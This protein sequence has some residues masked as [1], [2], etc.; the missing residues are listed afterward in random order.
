MGRVGV[1]YNLYTTPDPAMTNIAQSARINLIH[2]HP[3]MGR[4]VAGGHV[5]GRAGS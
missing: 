2:R 3:M 1:V 4:H 5:G